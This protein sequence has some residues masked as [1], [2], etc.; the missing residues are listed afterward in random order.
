MATRRVCCHVLHEFANT[1]G[2]CNLGNSISTWSI[3][4]GVLSIYTPDL[5]DIDTF[6]QQLENMPDVVQLPDVHTLYIDNVVPF[7]FNN[8]HSYKVELPAL[9]R[10]VLKRPV[11]IDQRFESCLDEYGKQVREV[12]FEE[13][14]PS[15]THYEPFPGLFSKLMKICSNVEAVYFPVWKQALDW[16]Q[17]GEGLF[18]NL[19]LVKLYLFTDTMAQ[20]PAETW[21]RVEGYFNILMRQKNFPS[22][23]KIELHGIAWALLV[24]EM[25]WTFIRA[26]RRGVE[27]SCNNPVAASALEQAK[28]E[29]R[30][31]FRR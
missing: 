4:A 14:L 29:L 17:V 2:Y 7:D 23:K 26:D 27:I 18:P 6:T 1:F 31:K 21:I 13:S 11:V 9:R 30:H 22:V 19:R 15:K 28:G 24:Y 8:D 3:Q 12:E 10:I 25:Q 5:D 16:C 20:T